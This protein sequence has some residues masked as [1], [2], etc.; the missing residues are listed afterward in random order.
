M[1]TGAVRGTGDEARAALGRAADAV[2][3]SPGALPPGL[4]NG[5]A[6]IAF[7]STFLARDG[8]R[9]GRWRREL[10]PFWERAALAWRTRSPA[11]ETRGRLPSST[12]FLD[13]REWSPASCRKILS[14]QWP[15]LP[16]RWVSDPPGASGPP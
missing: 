15:P 12:I 10:L 8:Q 11:V 2:A 6:G 13:W 16:V 3:A 9:H 5:W 7:A 1:R 4:A 14:G